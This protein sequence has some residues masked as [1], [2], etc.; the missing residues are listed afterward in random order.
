MRSGTEVAKA[1]VHRG[2]FRRECVATPRCNRK[3]VFR[4]TNP[5]TGIGKGGDRILEATWSLHPCAE[6]QRLNGENLHP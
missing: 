6:R 4:M 5:M 1:I 3:E 2:G